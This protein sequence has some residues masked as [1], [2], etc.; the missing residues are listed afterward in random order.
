MKNVFSRTYNILVISDDKEIIDTIKY[1]ID[2]V[3]RE[4]Y[5]ECIV[6]DT[7]LNKI[8]RISVCTSKHR[9]VLLTGM[10]SKSYPDICVFCKNAR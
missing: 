7:D 1:A 9:Y 4:K 3:T 2:I 10:L 5:G 6:Y 8:K